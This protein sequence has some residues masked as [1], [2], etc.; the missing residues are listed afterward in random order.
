M[1]AEQRPTGRWF[2]PRVRMLLARVVVVVGIAIALLALVTAR[3]GLLFVAVIVV[4]FGA[5]MSPARRR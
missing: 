2:T 3:W 4:G 5:A 1:T